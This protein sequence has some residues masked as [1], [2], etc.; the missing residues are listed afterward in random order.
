MTSFRA[1]YFG[2][3][4]LLLTATNLR[5][6]IFRGPSLCE[7]GKQLAENRPRVL[8]VRKKC[9]PNCRSDEK[10]HRYVAN[11]DVGWAQ[12]IVGGP[13]PDQVRYRSF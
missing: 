3:L 13:T 4:F 7:I 5:Y 10:K 9:C 8:A 1:A 12:I 11:M 2:V 6:R